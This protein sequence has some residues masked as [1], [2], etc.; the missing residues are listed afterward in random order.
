MTS[1]RRAFA[2]LVQRLDG[3]SFW[4]RT[5]CSLRVLFTENALAMVPVDDLFAFAQA[6]RLSTPVLT[7]KPVLTHCPF[8]GHSS[9]SQMDLLIL[10]T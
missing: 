7:R 8:A 6:M 4:T 5:C 3:V 1:P 9:G 10:N 2:A